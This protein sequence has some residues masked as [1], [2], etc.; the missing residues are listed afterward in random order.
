MTCSLTPDSDHGEAVT[1]QLRRSPAGTALQHIRLGAALDN[2]GIA[3]DIGSTTVAGHLLDLSTG[4]VLHSAG[5]MNQQI[6]LGE[7]LMSRV[8][9]VMMND[10]GAPNLRSLAR[11]TGWK[12][13]C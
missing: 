9:Y 5:S 11:D 6:R 3:I 2:L 4:E 7:D 1:V 10:D 8:S 13:N 12:A